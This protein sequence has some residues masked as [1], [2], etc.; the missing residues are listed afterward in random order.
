M[1]SG[2]RSS[3]REFL[4]G[5]SARRA[6]EQLLPAEAQ[7]LNAASVPAA[8]EFLIQIGRTAM[9]CDFD[10]FLNAG[11][12]PGAT[13]AAQ[14]ALDL[15]DAL[16]SQLTVYRPTSEV[17]EINRRA[18]REA[19]TVEPR[20][21][22]LLRR[23]VELH[24]RTGGAF[25]ITTGPLSK[26]WGFAQREG[27]FPAPNNVTAALAAVGTRWLELNDQANTI[28]FHRPEL[29]INLNA[30]GKGYSL[31]Q[32]ANLLTERGVG[33]FLIH[34]GHS[35][36]LARGSCAGTESPERGWRIALHHPL[37][38][39]RKLRDLMLVDQ[40][41]GTSGSANQFFHFQGRRY[42]HV[43]DPRTGYPADHVLSAT[44]LAGDAATAD[45][46]A[47][48]FFVMGVDSSLA[49]CA[50]HPGISAILVVAGKRA[51][52]VELVSVGIPDLLPTTDS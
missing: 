25:D 1:N 24:E 5:E 42:G 29:E 52:E 17:M 18:A 7:L 32:A 37:H 20:L 2:E 21:Y 30:I 41:L 31:D 13:E 14:A 10:V 44:V 22:Q 49:F 34:G 35:S 51:G 3:R 47:T 16:E 23:A 40:A 28:R 6:V 48:A 36:I 26:V 8:R 38:P 46:L 39:E 50:Q 43:I 4:A 9:A 11:Q 15:I 45:A 33:D 27:R 19:I 12:Y